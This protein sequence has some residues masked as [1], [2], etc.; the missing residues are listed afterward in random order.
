M[1]Y[2]NN[3]NDDHENKYISDVL[4]PRLAYFAHSTMRKNNDHIIS[5][6]GGEFREERA[7]LINL[8]VSRRDGAALVNLVVSRRDGAALINLVV[9]RRDGAALIN[10]VGSGRDSSSR[11]PCGFMERGQLS[12]TLWFQ[13]GTAAVL[14]LVF[15]V[16]GREGSCPQPCVC[17]FRERGQLSSTLCLWFQGESAAVLNLMFVV[18]GRE[19]SCCQP[20]VCGF[21]ERG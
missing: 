6:R 4:C 5:I 12:S 9:S 7:A 17:G 1:V 11:Q 20:H 8:V 13:G 14:N 10:L 15:V 2:L 16:S 3:K 21:R 18:S 19:G